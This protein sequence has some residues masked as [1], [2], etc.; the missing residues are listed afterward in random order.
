MARASVIEAPNSAAEQAWRRF[1]SEILDLDNKKITYE[2]FNAAYGRNPE[3][4]FLIIKAQVELIAKES[5]IEALKAAEE[6][7]K[8]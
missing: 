4:V 8:A 5:Q 7:K 1:L 2:T 3:I 6:A